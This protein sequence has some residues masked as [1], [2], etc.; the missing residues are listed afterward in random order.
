MNVCENIYIHVSINDAASTCRSLILK[1]KRGGNI[2]SGPA[3][4]N[5]I[6]SIK[7]KRE[8]IK[9]ETDKICEQNRKYIFE[10]KHHAIFSKQQ[11]SRSP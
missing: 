2:M 11:Y 5:H 6:K 3:I 8:I 4:L 9:N 1:K 10:I 7:S